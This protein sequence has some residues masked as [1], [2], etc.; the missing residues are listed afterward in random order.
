MSLEMRVRRVV[1]RVV[2]AAVREARAAGVVVLESET[3]EGRM[4]AAW[5]E[6]GQALGADRVWRAAPLA[7]NVHEAA[8]TA[9]PCNRTALLLGGRLP[10]ADLLPLG[11]VYASEAAVL[12]GG[13]SAPAPVRELAER[14]GGIE[15]IDAALRRWLDQRHDAATALAPLGAAGPELARL[16][17]EGRWFRLRQRLVPKLGQRT[18]GVDL[19][20]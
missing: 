13:W 8:L 12:A 14:A 5:L 18:L 19:W 1:C 3:P 20:D 7:S 6:D 2:V 10:L 9:H 16:F 17:D 4:L 11:D 15:V